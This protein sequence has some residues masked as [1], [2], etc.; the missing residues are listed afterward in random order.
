VSG[1]SHHRAIFY[2]ANDEVPLHTVVC[3]RSWG[4][5]LETV[6]TKDDAS[7]SLPQSRLRGGRQDGYDRGAASRV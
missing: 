4:R 6:V 7:L 3:A 1:G 5:I 2:S